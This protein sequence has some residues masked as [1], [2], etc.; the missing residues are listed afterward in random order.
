MEQQRLFD[1]EEG[2][3]LVV[4]E[5]EVRDQIVDVMATAIVAVALRMTEV[6]DELLGAS[7]DQA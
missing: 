1:Q 2:A 7:Q 4:M 6:D 5:A 3:H